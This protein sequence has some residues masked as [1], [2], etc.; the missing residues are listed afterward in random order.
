[1]CNTKV[2]INEYMKLAMFSCACQLN[3]FAVPNRNKENPLVFGS[4]ENEEDL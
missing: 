2:Q 4:F 3:W 1:V